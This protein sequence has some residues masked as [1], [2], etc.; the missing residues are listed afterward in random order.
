[1]QSFKTS[2]H[3]LLTI[4][5]FLLSRVLLN[6]QEVTDGQI[7]LESTPAEVQ[8]S[9]TK[10]LNQARQRADEVHLSNPYFKSHF[11]KS[12]VSISPRGNDL[13]WHWQLKEL[14]VYDATGAEVA[15]TF[16][17]CLDHTAISVE[18]EALASAT[19]PVTIDP[20]IGPDD[21]RISTMGPE[22]NVNFDAS[23]PAVAYNSVDNNY[24]VVWSGEDTIDSLAVNELEIFGQLI[25]N[26]GA[27]T[28]PV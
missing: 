25:T 11:T 5:L 24:L 20:E 15:A 8:T 17:V 13:V 6:A 16:E 19:F 14:Y 23:T 27:E 7:N 3:L 1:M 26:L 12:S 10:V 9:L 4:A 21:F 22:G 18:E 28:G 2:T